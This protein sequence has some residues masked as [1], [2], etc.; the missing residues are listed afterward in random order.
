MSIQEK[1][2]RGQRD[3]DAI[4][5]SLEAHEGHETQET[6]VR[7]FDSHGVLWEACG[8]DDAGAEA[9]GP[10]GI[11]TSRR[12]ELSDV[13]LDEQDGKTAYTIAKEAGRVRTEDD[14]SGV[15]KWSY[16]TE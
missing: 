4:Q 14:G 8:A 10:S 1:G 13:G 7:F 15:N 11:S 2:N 9:F 12:I 3:A 6:P 16:L 5:T